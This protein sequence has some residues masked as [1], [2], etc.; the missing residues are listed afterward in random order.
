MVCL[1]Q[2]LILIGQRLSR[3]HWVG[4]IPIDL[5]LRWRRG[6]LW[7]ELRPS[8]VVVDVVWRLAPYLRLLTANPIFYRNPRHPRKRK[9]RRWCPPIC[10]R[11]NSTL[12]EMTHGY[13]GRVV[14]SVI[15][16]FRGWDA[17]VVV[18]YGDRALVNDVV[19]NNGVLMELNRITWM[20]KGSVELL[21]A[22]QNNNI[23]QMQT[24]TRKPAFCVI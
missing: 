13:L 23:V 17:V 6:L 4:M 8:R 14:A 3:W 16:L 24:I 15:L 21:I 10:S 1:R 22:I 5:R 11:N 20:N 12:N 18:I 9:Q 2:A 7:S 19:V